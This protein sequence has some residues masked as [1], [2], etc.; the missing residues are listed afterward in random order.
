VPIYP[1][2]SVNLLGEDGNAFV[3]ISRVRRA[4]KDNRLPESAIENYTREAMSG[5]Y[6]VVLQATMKYVDVS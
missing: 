2:V 6:D 4:M 3:I 5:D 1:Q